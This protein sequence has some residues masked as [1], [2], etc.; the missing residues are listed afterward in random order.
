MLDGVCR[1][2]IGKYKLCKGSSISTCHRIHYVMQRAHSLIGID[3]TIRTSLLYNDC[4][5]EKRSGR[6]VSGDSIR[7][8]HSNDYQM[9]LTYSLAISRRLL[10]AVACRV[11]LQKTR[12]TQSHRLPHLAYTLADCTSDPVCDGVLH[13]A[14]VRHSIPLLFLA[15]CNHHLRVL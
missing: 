11:H 1:L 14:V 8:S 5:V 6:W 3:A 12:F 9:L 2:L 7:S 4:W 15:R 13:I 10:L